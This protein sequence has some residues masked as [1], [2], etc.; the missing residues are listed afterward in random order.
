MAE[1]YLGQLIL[2]PYNFAPR[3]TAFCAGQILP[4]SQN[5]A[6]FSL[7]G[8]NFGGNGQTTFALPDLR[9]RAVM[10]QGQGPGLSQYV[11]GEQSGSESIIL[12][13]TEMPAHAHQ[14]MGSSLPADLSQVGGNVL[15]GGGSLNFYAPGISSSGAILN[16]TAVGM[17]G[18]NQAHENRMPFLTLNWIIALE[19]I[20]PAR[21]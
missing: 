13:I 20:F 8:T 10:G 17:A 21:N 4:I 12:N 7:L 19:G 2:V 1:F 11:I 18:G 16:Q 6:L 14:L 9:G 5:T 3:G 15:A